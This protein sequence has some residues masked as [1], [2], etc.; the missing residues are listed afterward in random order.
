MFTLNGILKKDESKEYN[1]K[2]GTIGYQRTLYIE[3]IGSIYPVA[4]SVSDL[5]AEYGKHG[6]TVSIEVSVFP[7]TYVD[8]KR[9]RAYSSVYIPKK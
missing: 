6:D 1:R 5:D 2:D 7:F 9:R 3:P 8:G 4:V